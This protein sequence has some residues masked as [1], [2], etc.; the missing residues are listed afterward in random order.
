MAQASASRKR[1]AAQEPAGSTNVFSRMGYDTADDRARRYSLGAIILHWA[2][3]LLIVANV[4]IALLAEDMPRAEAMGWMAIHKANGITVLLLALVRIG[5]RL[6]HAWPPLPAT[7]PRWQAKLARFTHHVFYVGIIA[8]PLA[9]YI[10]VSAASG[11]KPI[12]MYGLFDFP[13]LPLA[14]DRAGAGLGK[15]IHVI[16]AFATVGLVALHVAGALKHAFADGFF[17]MWPGRDA[18]LPG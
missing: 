12:D 16:L 18:A 17:R 8:V 4:V 15:Q 11:G 14:Q 5:W 10:F 7:I 1:G 13:G 9:G 6:T 3:A 2:I